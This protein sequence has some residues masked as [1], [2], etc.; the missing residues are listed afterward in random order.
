MSLDPSV[1]NRTHIGRKYD[2]RFTVLSSEDLEPDQD[3]VSPCSSSE[4]TPGAA[5]EDFTFA[6]AFDFSSLRAQQPI[7]VE[8]DSDHVQSRSSSGDASPIMRRLM[9]RV[10]GG[11]AVV[12]CRRSP[13]TSP[14]RPAGDS[15]TTAFEKEVAAVAARFSS[16]SLLHTRLQQL[17]P[18]PPDSA[19]VNDDAQRDEICALRSILGRDVLHSGANYVCWSLPA[20]LPEGASSV[21]LQP[22]ALSMSLEHLPDVVVTAFLPPAYP[23]SAPPQ[24][25]FDSPWLTPGTASRCAEEAAAAWTPGCECLYAAHQAAS[26]TVARMCVQ[27]VEV[28]LS[29]LAS[30]RNIRARELAAQALFTH[31]SSRQ[32]EV[33]QDTFFD[34]RLC[35]VSKS[36]AMSHRLI[37]CKHVYAT[38]IPHC[39][40]VTFCSCTATNASAG[41]SPLSS[42]RV[43]CN[44]W[45]VP[46]LAAAPHPLTWSCARFWT[47]KTTPGVNMA[48]ANSG[49]VCL[50]FL[51]S[52]VA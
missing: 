24:F 38:S 19:A 34:C 45:S 1:P 15:D 9:V 18:P 5:A 4:P 12:L 48:R 20:P 25:F 39:I 49:L 29:L 40:F 31:S 28:D 7:A 46:A 2:A 10:E 14:S 37:L 52:R 27:R 32:A 16:A 23:S 51:P 47:T 36:G 13:S 41:S 35:L 42:A 30:A 8:Q 22:W 21:L 11:G 50:T 26:E 43:R 17:P 6:Q 3:G 44:R 33:F